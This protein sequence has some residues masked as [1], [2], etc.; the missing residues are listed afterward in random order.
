MTKQ[1]TMNQLKLLAGL[2]RIARRHSSLLLLSL[3]LGFGYYAYEVKIARPALLYQGEPRALSAKNTDTW[4]RILRNH[5][6]ILGYSDLRGNPLWVEY[7]L[8][9][10][11]ENG[12]S[13]KRPSRFETDWRSINRVSHD[14]Y[15]KSGYDRGHMAPNY[16]ISRLYGKQG[17]AD[18]FL[19]TNITPQKPNLNQ[20]LWQRLE[21]AEIDLFAKSFGKVWVIT[22]PVFTGTVE[23][24][25]SD[26]TVEI[27]DAF[28]KI[29]ITEATP[30]AK[31]I[32]LAFL[33]PQTVNGKEPL[34]RF[35]TSIDKIE[36]QTGL[37][38]FADLD[39]ST[40]N[41]LEAKIDEQPWHL[42]AVNQRPSRY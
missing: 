11:S 20:K 21:E 37:D 29:Y 42:Q 30:A 35:V 6:F 38:F 40:E 14:S 41:V 33:V 28:Y 27:P 26:W 25:V 22:G 1:K 32:V 7:A 3:T 36:A 17:Q 4:F 13:L 39:D 8:T 5:G 31:P 12:H 10:A 18:S 34:A 16:A 19:M 15:Q 2:F 24:L 9:P 23:R